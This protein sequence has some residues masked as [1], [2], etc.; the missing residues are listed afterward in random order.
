LNDLTDE[1]RMGRNAEELIPLLESQDSGVVGVATYI[2]KEIDPDAY[3]SP[4]F[5][6]RL[7][8]LLSHQ[9][10]EVR[11]NAV[12]ALWPFADKECQEKLRQI[13]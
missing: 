9:A 4:K 12:G 7:K 8:R 10:F 3:S 6:E 1:F 5:I 11:F 2:L 13:D